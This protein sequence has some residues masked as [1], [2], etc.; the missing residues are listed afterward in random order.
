MTKTELEIKAREILATNQK[1]L[2]RIAELELELSKAE[3]RRETELSRARFIIT[4]TLEQLKVDP[5]KAKQVMQL[6][7]IM[8]SNSHKVV[9]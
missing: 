1:L 4:T 7:A 5:A 9:R 6:A 3:L 8:W 2:D